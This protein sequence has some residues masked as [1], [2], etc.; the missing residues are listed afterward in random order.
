MKL[1]VVSPKNKAIC[2]FLTI[3]I[4]S[5][6]GQT[7]VFAQ[8]NNNASSSLSQSSKLSS[9]ENKYLDYNKNYSSAK[10]ATNEI[11]IDPIDVLDSKD[12]EIKDVLGIK[13]L[14]S[15]E[16]G[17]VSYK[18]VV[19]QTARYILNLRY[20]PLAGKNS[21]I[22]RELLIDGLYPFTE[23]RSIELSRI[24]ENTDSSVKVDRNGNEYFNGFSE[25]YK[26]TDY[27]FSDN[28]GY[29]TNPFEIYLEAGSHTITLNSI[30]EPMAISKISFSP[31]KS[32]LTYSEYN[33]KNKGHSNKDENEPIII[34]AEKTR[35]VS[36]TVLFPGFDRSSPDT[37]PVSDYSIKLNMISGTQ[38]QQAGQWIEWET[39]IKN[40]GLYNISF[41]VRQNYNDG[42]FT[43]RKL[44]IDGVVPFAEAENIA[45]KYDGVWQLV[46]A[47]GKVNYNLYLTKGKHQIKLQN[48]LGIMADKIA[49]VDDVLKQLNKSYLDIMTITGPSPD[50]FRDYKL[51]K[52]IPET[53]K[54]LGI[55]SD[56]LYKVI[57]EIL[58]TSGVKGS[59]ISSLE[60]IAL[61]CKQMS[62]DPPKIPKMFGS[63]ENDLG[64]LSFWITN[65]QMQPLDIDKIYISSPETKLA[66]GKSNIFQ[67]FWHKFIV[68]Y[69]SFFNDINSFN[70]SKG[71]SSLKVW[72]GSGIATGRDQAMVLKKMIEDTFTPEEKINI[73]FQLVAGGSLLPASLSGRGPDVALRIAATD[74]MNYALRGAVLDISKFPDF[75]EVTKQYFESALVP[76]TYKGKSYAL[77]EVQT[78]P[79]MFYREDIL[80][81]LGIKPPETWD[82]V[83][84]ILPELQ[85][86][87]MNFAIPVTNYSTNEAFSISGNQTNGFKSYA[88]M[89]FQRNG[90]FYRENGKYSA[91]DGK[92]QTEVFKQWT[93]LYRDYKLP[94]A[95]EF[96]NRF[97]LGE[98]PVG[99]AD[100]TIYN[101]LM[102]YFPEIKGLWKFTSVPGTRQEDGTINHSV[103]GDVQGAIIL[104]NTSKE[105]NAWKFIKFW[106]D[107][108]TQTR[109]GREM[110]AILG[111]SGRWPSANIEAVKQTAWNSSDLA[112]LLQQFQYVKGVP[113]VP[114]GYYTSRYLD[115]SF[116]RVV[117]YKDNAKDTLISNVRT[118]N[119]ELQTKL[120]EFGFDK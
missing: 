98:I 112:N 66:A 120:T 54:N 111:P 36:D 64:S 7:F 107:K 39:D 69:S 1:T 11:I 22:E 16:T 77:P 6:F 32:M 30:K 17:Y 2:I 110:E 18:F 101:S 96:A 29:F 71:K 42:M 12:T 43:S 20:S 78:F 40:D 35:Y 86:N 13:S 108:K 56:R 45:F 87:N 28:F 92:I 90:E 5:S 53:I 73:D 67:V 21:K 80:D 8:E 38:W 52:L 59:Y 118:I 25:V 61:E 44:Y 115:L 88:M 84:D 14:V 119:E 85:R 94:L 4:L 102:V 83:Y 97:A 3:L 55:Q 93:S 116:R 41:R 10:T 48:T 109:F 104:K 46:T 63:F 62:Y 58:Q 50:L 114:G 91:L 72:L 100:Y 27:T 113:E 33:E 106:T 105:E 89:L 60:K 37:T 103:A 9:N 57:S 95:Y 19:R 26:W 49:A 117:Y 99:V 82:D 23:A 74:A 51:E 24:Y 70:D 75:K 31:L 68:F 76:L 81:K 47:G 34:E 65:S 79:V 15:S